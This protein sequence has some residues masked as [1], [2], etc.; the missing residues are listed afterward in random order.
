M[1]ELAEKRGL[2]EKAAG[3]LASTV[4]LRA[5]LTHSAA[6]LKTAGS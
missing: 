1:I 5:M 4:K 2:Q 6:M 3:L